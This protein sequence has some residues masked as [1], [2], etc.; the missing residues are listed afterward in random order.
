MQFKEIATKAGAPIAVVSGRMDA[1]V[2]KLGD[3]V[4]LELLLTALCAAIPFILLAVE[5]VPP[6][7]AISGFH[8][9]RD[10][11][12]F[13]MPLTIAALLFVVNGVRSGQWYNV[14]LGTALAGLTF[15]NTTDY[16]TIHLVFTVAF[17]LG[18][19]IVFVV[20]SPKDELW[21]KWLLAL[22]MAAAIVSWFVFGWIHIF[23]AESISL[24]LIAIHFAF[25]ALGW[26]R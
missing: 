7:E 10:P 17:F 1:A 25:E 4:K 9:M 14:A 13:Y 15:F 5:G 3:L 19:P 22:A 23:W 16:P 20:F 6:A 18:N 8:D 2:S 12:F 24:W 11:E 21:F 26:I